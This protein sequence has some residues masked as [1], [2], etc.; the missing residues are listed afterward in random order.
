MGREV[1]INTGGTDV[2]NEKNIIFK[3][4]LISTPDQIA[5]NSPLFE[6][7]ENVEELAV[8]GAFTYMAGNFPNYAEAEKLLNTAYRQFPDASIVAFKDGKNIRLER[9]LRQLR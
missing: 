6:G 7:I 8:S 4:H 3:V 2:A 5:L 9:A 1:Y